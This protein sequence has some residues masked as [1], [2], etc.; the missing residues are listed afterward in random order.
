MCNDNRL[1]FENHQHLIVF[2]HRVMS[3]RLL[4]TLSAFS[5]IVLCSPLRM[6]EEDLILVGNG[7]MIPT[8][9]PTCPEEDDAA[10]PVCFNN[11]ADCK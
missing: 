5:V 11:P 8:P 6:E 10:K 7:K 4:V 9:D 1:D 2:S 3:S